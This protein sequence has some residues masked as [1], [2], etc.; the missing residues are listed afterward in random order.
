MLE[1]NNYNSS[2]L[3]DISFS[4]NENENLI[5][6]GQNGAGKSTLAKVLSNLIE[7]DEVKLFDV[8]INDISDDKRASLINYIPPK[9][10]IFDEYITLREFLELSAINNNDNNSQIDKIIELLSLKKLENRF[11]KAFS[12]GEKQLLLL[13][14]AIMHNAKITIFD[15]LTANLDITR[16][17]EVYDIFKSDFLQQKIVITHNLDLA[18]ALKFKVLYLKDGQIK[19]YGSNEEFFSNE[20]LQKFYNN[21]IIKLDKHLVVNL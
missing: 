1:I 7:N 11:C 5:I 21:S 17:K 19:F 4:L 3:K 6:L 9:L 18:Y 15:E 13:G 16:L 14:S 12:S 8:N 20:N 2:I 10:E